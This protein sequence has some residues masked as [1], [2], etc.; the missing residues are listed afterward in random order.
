MCLCYTDTC[1]RKKN[2]VCS[3]Y[4]AEEYINLLL[5]NIYSTFWICIHYFFRLCL[6]IFPERTIANRQCGRCVSWAR[7]LPFE[8][9]VA[10]KTIKCLIWW[11]VLFLIVSFYFGVWH[12]ERL[13]SPL[14]PLLLLAVR[15]SKASHCNVLKHICERHAWARAT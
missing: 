14:P 7:Q 8:K 12:V 6:R 10:L 1:T 4:L 9:P 2:F 3:S 13:L 11:M 15:I 5:T